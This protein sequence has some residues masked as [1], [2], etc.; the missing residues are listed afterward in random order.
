M[1]ED[2]PLVS[3]LMDIRNEYLAHRASRLV[4]S[5]PF[6]GI[7]KLEREDIEALLQRASSIGD[8]YGQLC[9]RP[10][11]LRGY[12]GADNYSYMLKF[13]RLGLQSKQERDSGSDLTRPRTALD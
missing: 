7:A 8:R 3:R 13:V 5:G 6:D 4:S 2:D 11:V 9:G 10:H 1:S 12:P